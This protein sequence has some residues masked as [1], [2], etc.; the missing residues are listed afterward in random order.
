MQVSLDNTENIEVPGYSSF[1]EYLEK[2]SR[3]NSAYLKTLPSLLYET[4]ES[5]DV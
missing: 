5:E 4:L 3:L 1:T 2:L